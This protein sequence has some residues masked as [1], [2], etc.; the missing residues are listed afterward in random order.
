V[1]VL[2]T[3]ASPD[4]TRPRGTTMAWIAQRRRRNVVIDRVEGVLA[5]GPSYDTRADA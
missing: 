5:K 2:E 1:T 4:R 3:P